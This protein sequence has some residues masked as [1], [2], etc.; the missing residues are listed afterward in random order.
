MNAGTI[1]LLGYICM[2]SVCVSIN[3]RYDNVKDCIIEGNYIKSIL[4]KNNIR[5]YMM[6]CVDAKDYEET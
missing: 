2:N 1:F 5:K 3:G 4:D 6:L